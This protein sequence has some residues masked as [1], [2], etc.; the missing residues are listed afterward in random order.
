VKEIA[1]A[2]WNTADGTAAA[3]D[4]LDRP[5]VGAAIFTP[6][7]VA[8]DATFKGVAPSSLVVWLA[9][10][11]VGCYTFHVAGSPVMTVGSRYAVFLS[12]TAATGMA[13]VPLQVR[14]AWTTNPDGSINTPA[15]GRMSA[16][17]FASAVGA[18]K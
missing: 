3:F 2:R 4:D 5:R 6:V 1:T 16:A 17:A 9:G 13:T 7:T 14:A 12:P 11:T 10:G 15:D 8:I 18:V